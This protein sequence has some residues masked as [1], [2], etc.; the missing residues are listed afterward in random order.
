[1]TNYNIGLSAD[2]KTAYVTIAGD[3][4]PGGATDV[5]TDFRHGSGETADLVSDNPANHVL[6]NDVQEALYRQREI[7]DMQA[8]SIVVSGALAAQYMSA[9][10]LNF[11]HTTTATIVIKYQPANV[12]AV[13]A[14]FTYVSSV[15]A[16]ATVDA[17]GVVTGVA[18]G[19]TVITA[20]H[21]VTGKTIDIPV[22]LS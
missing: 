4:L 5:L 13:N 7:Q 21:K 10:A 11:A 22:T 6:Y 8:I 2:K 18:A 15:P 12:S 16:K 3:A 1:M 19:A 20:T 9:A 14:D 17:A